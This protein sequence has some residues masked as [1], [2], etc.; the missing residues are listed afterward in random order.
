[1]AIGTLLCLGYL[2]RLDD[3]LEWVIELS[4]EAFWEDKVLDILLFFPILARYR[5]FD[6]VSSFLRHLRS[7]GRRG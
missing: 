1:M 4:D 3:T 7:K 6:P 2:K 5:D